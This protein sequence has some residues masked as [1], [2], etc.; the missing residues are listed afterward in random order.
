[1]LQFIFDAA[2]II[3]GSFTGVNFGSWLYD[4]THNHE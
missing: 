4:K 3:L 2:A 1:M